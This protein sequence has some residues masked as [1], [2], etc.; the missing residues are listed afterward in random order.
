MRKL[1][2]VVPQDKWP[3]TLHNT[4]ILA[5]LIE[6]EA[7]LPQERSI[8]ASVYLNRLNRHILLQC[9]PTVSYALAQADQYQGRLTL[10]DL[11]FKSPYN[12]YLYP[13]L[14]PGPIANP[15]Y[16]SLLAAIQPAETK[17]LYF[18]RTTEERHTF[19]E[20]LEAHNRAVAAY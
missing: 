10:A 12:T 1:R 3:L 6:T 7:A 15:G 13:G 4:V 8:I 17:Y 2:E 11:H 5:S 14:P 20:T 9:D 19:S 18:V 16:A